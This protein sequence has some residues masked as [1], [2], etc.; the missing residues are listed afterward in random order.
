M[1]QTAFSH[2]DQPT[3]SR[4]E[5][6]RESLGMCWR[7]LWAVVWITVINTRFWGKN[8]QTHKKKDPSTL[9]RNKMMLH[10]IVEIMLQQMQSKLK[11]VLSSIRV[12]AFCDQAVFFM[13]HW[14]LYT[15]MTQAVREKHFTSNTLIFTR[16]FPTHL[17]Q[18][19]ET[20]RHYTFFTFGN[21]KDF[22]INSIFFLFYTLNSVSFDIHVV[23]KM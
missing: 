2:K 13:R 20:I 16:H 21:S 7:R 12:W 10:K 3:E 14:E 17:K 18:P 15:F 4:P 9:D 11:E 8:T 5:L 19:T 23:F 1:Y 22:N 6:Y